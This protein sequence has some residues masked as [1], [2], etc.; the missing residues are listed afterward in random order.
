MLVSAHS[1]HALPTSLT[2]PILSGARGLPLWCDVSALLL[3]I[4]LPMNCAVPWPLAFTLRCSTS[5]AFL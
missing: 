3:A 5:A 1:C 4:Q 2:P